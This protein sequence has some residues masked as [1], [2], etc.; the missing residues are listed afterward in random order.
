[1]ATEKVVIENKNTEAPSESFMKSISR[2]TKE[3]KDGR[4]AVVNTLVRVFSSK[5]GD[6]IKTDLE[7]QAETFEADVQ[8]MVKGELTYSEMRALYG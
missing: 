5:E 4:N 6:A 1:M 2:F 3:V 7:Q 8:K